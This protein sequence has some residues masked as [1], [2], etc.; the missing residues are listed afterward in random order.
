MLGGPL[1]P[2]PIVYRLGK[3]CPTPH[4]C[5]DVFITNLQLYHDFVLQCLIMGIKKLLLFNL[6]N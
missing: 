3:Y 5:V 2:G 4:T 6:L 1:S